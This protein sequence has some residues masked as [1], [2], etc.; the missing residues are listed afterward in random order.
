M[1][2]SFFLNLVCLFLAGSSVY[3]Q[4]VHELLLT[5]QQ[6][7]TKLAKNLRDS[8]N[9]DEFQRSLKVSKLF[10]EFSRKMENAEK[11]P[12]E[13]LDVLQN[14]KAVLNKSIDGMDPQ[15]VNQTLDYLYTDINLKYESMPQLNGDWSAIRVP[16][17]VKVVNQTGQEQSGYNVFAKF[18][19]STD[20]VFSEQFNPTNNA[21]KEML[22]GWYLFWISKDGKKI[23]ERSDHVRRTSD[24]NI[25]VFNIQ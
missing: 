25:I 13:Y 1:R 10:S 7:L 3:A 16:V 5:D 8:N 9:N 24:K 11:Y 12:P 21:N 2:K 4:G 22:P 15:S 23:S 14:Y 18:Y 6:L 19:L 17:T 20:Y